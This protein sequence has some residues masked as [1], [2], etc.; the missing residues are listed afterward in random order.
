MS[1]ILGSLAW[2]HRRCSFRNSR[3]TAHA[4]RLRRFRALICTS[5]LDQCGSLGRAAGLPAGGGGGGSPPCRR[6]RLATTCGS[7]L[8]SPKLQAPLG[9]AACLP[10]VMSWLLA[11]ASVQL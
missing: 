8:W 11:P 10:I 5:N 1:I 9:S 2:G 7:R 4:S 6:P 3:V